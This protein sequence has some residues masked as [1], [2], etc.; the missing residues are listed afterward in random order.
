ML[1]VV[2]SSPPPPVLFFRRF[3]QSP[4]HRCPGRRSCILKVPGTYLIHYVFVF[5]SGQILGREQGVAS[6]VS[7]GTSAPVDGLH[8]L[9]VSVL[10]GKSNWS[11]CSFRL[12]F[13]LQPISVAQGLQTFRERRMGYVQ[14]GRNDQVSDTSVS[15]HACSLLAYRCLL[16]LSSLLRSASR[17][18]LLLL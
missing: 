9:M 7:I 3:G 18:R 13:F 17:V 16:L 8:L 10:C 1:D 14:E 6:Y 2:S 4:W 12:I 5:A 11:F 15:D